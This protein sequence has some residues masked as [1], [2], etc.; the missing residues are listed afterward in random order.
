MCCRS[1]LSGPGRLVGRSRGTP[2]PEVFDIT[3]DH[4]IMS[5]R[6]DTRYRG[7]GGKDLEA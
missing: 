7:L 3:L 6:S 5:R 2:A 1:R 4:D